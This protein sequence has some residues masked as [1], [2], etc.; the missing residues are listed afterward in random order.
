MALESGGF[1]EV[2]A[3]E[4]RLPSEEIRRRLLEKDELLAELEA[5]NPRRI[6][7]PGAV[8]EFTPAEIAPKLTSRITADG[9]KLAGLAS[10]AK[11]TDARA[12][13]LSVKAGLARVDAEVARERLNA[14]MRETGIA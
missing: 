5:R 12:A 8:I 11:R 9:R 7:E 1:V 13:A 2:T 10:W 14:Y 6:I 3:E 4:L